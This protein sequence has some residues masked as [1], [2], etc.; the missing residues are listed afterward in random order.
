M[1]R[2]W[3]SVAWIVL[4]VTQLFCARPSA[5]PPAD[6]SIGQIEKIKGGVQV[7]PETAL[8]N[9]EPSSP[10][11]NN[12]LVHVFNKGKASLDFGAGLSFTL[13]NDTTSC[14]ASPEPVAV[15]DIVG[16]TVT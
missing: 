1:N 16:E 13:Y 6:L 11:Y 12:D 9:V 5:T 3:I 4:L 14:V 7:G 10:V 15:T 8:A 2:V